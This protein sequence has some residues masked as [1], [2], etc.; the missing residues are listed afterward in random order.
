MMAYRATAHESTALI[1]NELML[2]REVHM[3]IDIQV[4]QPPEEPEGTEHEYLENLRIRLENDYDLARE[5]LGTSAVHQRRYY[6]IKAIDEP[7][8]PGY[9]LVGE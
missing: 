6:D 3:P 2:G 7:Y 1:P 4:G 8:R 9:L 5:N